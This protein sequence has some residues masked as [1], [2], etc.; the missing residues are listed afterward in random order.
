MPDA[1]YVVVGAGSAGAVLAAR[2][3]EDSRRTVLV[4]EAG[5]DYPLESD[6][7]PDLLDGLRLAGMAHDWGYTA[8]PTAARTMPYRRGRVVGGTGAINAAAAMW[9]RPSDMERWAGLGNADWA[10]PQVEPWLRRVEQDVDALRRATHGSTGPIP[11]RRFPTGQFIP[12][13]RAFTDAC[14]TELGLSE[15]ADHN[16]I[17]EAGGVAPWPMKRL[18]DGTR[19][20]TALAYLAPARVRANL[21]V[22]GNAL[23]DRVV[24]DGPRAAVVLLAGGGVCRARRGVIL[25]AG[26]LATP[27]ILMR[28][29]IGDPEA[30]AAVGIPCVQAR[31]GVG[32]R[33][34][35]HPSVPVR[36]VP[37]PG[38]CDPLRDPRFQ[39]VA[40]L[41][42]A[43]DAPLFLVLVSFLDIS[44]S[45]AMVSEAGGARVVALVSTALMDPRGHGSLRL[46][47]A[48]PQAPPVID[49]GFDRDETDLQHLAEGVRLAWRVARSAPITANSERLAGLD[50]ATIGSDARLREYIL[51]NV[52]SFN[53]PCGTAPMGP[54]SDPAA[55]ADQ[56]GR[57]HG[58]ERLW[59]A[60]ASLMPRGV[61]VPPNLTIAVIGERIAAWI[62][63]SNE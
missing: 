56:H 30:L 15:V 17:T 20:S 11:I 57:V 19:V 33:L 58:I 8:A 47:S 60:D 62:R 42:T 28:S 59:I 22:R 25:C 3:S 53:H 63:Q 40:R 10:W 13:Q 7:P 9:P 27:A 6:M 18:A 35:E 16:D 55:V 26:A 41:T 21:Q 50:D 39:A 34:Y 52:G 24:L 44:A 2:L 51:A 54:A 31:P 36:L 38:E 5:Q 1:D 61:T 12:M 37:K 29:G 49:L 23:V 45:G 14:R 4:L 48:D 32:A 46:A 43:D